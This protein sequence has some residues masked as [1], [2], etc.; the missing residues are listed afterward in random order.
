MRLGYSLPYAFLFGFKW[1]ITAFLN[2]MKL[3][4]LSRVGV[5]QN[6]V[7]LSMLFIFIRLGVVCQEY[8]AFIFVGV[9]VVLL[10]FSIAVKA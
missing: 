1:E 9:C 4:F 5:D 6:I 3:I 2:V 10:F 8:T 7:Y